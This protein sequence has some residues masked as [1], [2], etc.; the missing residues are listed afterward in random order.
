MLGSQLG[1]GG[2]IKSILYTHVLNVSLKK[3]IPVWAVNWCAK[4]ES[5][6]PDPSKASPIWEATFQHWF[7]FHTFTNKLNAFHFCT[8]RGDKFSI[9]RPLLESTPSWIAAP[10][11]H[12]PILVVT[13]HVAHPLAIDTCCWTPVPNDDSNYPL[14]ALAASWMLVAGTSAVLTLTRPLSLQYSWKTLSSCFCSSI[15]DPEASTSITSMQSSTR[16]TGR[17]TIQLEFRHIHLMP[18]SGYDQSGCSFRHRPIDCRISRLFALNGV[19]IINVRNIPKRT[20]SIF[21]H[22]FT[23]FTLNHTEKT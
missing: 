9:Y 21:A 1:A 7:W 22:Q 4:M 2:P 3:F 15:S 19:Y 16:V 6:F 10:L 17:N 8:M 13:E 5:T 12:P 11:H 20:L 23:L 18:T 14:I